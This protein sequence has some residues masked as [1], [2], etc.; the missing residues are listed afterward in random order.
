MKTTSSTT[1][2]GREGNGDR[3]LWEAWEAAREGGHVALNHPLVLG[4]MAPGAE[5]RTLP[6]YNWEERTHPLQ[7]WGRYVRLLAGGRGPSGEGAMAA[8]TVYMMSAWAAA[9]GPTASYSLV[10]PSHTVVVRTGGS[11][12][13]FEPYNPTEGEVMSLHPS[14]RTVMVWR[15]RDLTEDTGILLM[16]WPFPLTAEELSR[17]ARDDWTG[18]GRSG[19]VSGHAPLEWH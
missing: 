7:P 5:G 10:G 18:G 16:D 8:G 11:L 1:D 12:C 15:G 2:A 17:V 3:S 6:P 9:D 14:A 19:I 13:G 4:L